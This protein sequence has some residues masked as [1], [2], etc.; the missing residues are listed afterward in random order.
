MNYRFLDGFCGYQQGG[1]YNTIFWQRRQDNF[2]PPLS[3]HTD[4]ILGWLIGFDPA[5][6]SN[7]IADGSTGYYIG[8]L[9]HRED[10]RSV[11]LESPGK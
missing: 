4:V 3:R 5:E 2:G 1:F 8:A 11:I 9:L 7:P 6:P 10:E